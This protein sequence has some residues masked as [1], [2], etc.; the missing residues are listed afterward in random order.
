MFSFYLLQKHILVDNEEPLLS[1]QPW[2]SQ[3]ETEEVNLTGLC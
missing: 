2:V 1:L 3:K